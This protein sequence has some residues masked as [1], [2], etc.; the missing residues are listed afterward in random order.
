MRS[1]T[2]LALMLL[3]AA[4]LLA[5]H[6]VVPHITQQ[7][8]YAVEKGQTLAA[9]EQLAELSKKDHT[10]QLFRAVAKAVKPAVVEVHVTTNVTVGG[11]SD[12]LEEFFRDRFGDDVPFR[13]PGPPGGQPREVPRRG[14][15]SGVIIDAEEGYILTNHHVVRGADE[16]EV[17]LA[18]KRRF[19]TEWVRSDP[20]TDLAVL[21]IK[22]DRLIDAPIGDS[23]EMQVG[24]WVMAIGAPERLPQTVTAGI[25]SATSRRTG[26]VLYENFLQTDAAINKG[27]SGG[28]LVNMRGEVI[29][30]NTMIISRTGVNEG[31]GLSIP[32]NMA[33]DI[34]R[35]LIDDGRVTRGY[36]GVQIKDV[37][38]RLAEGL[39]LP[40]T[41]GSLMVQVFEG[42]PAAKAGLQV[43]DFIT[44]IDGEKIDNSDDLR[45][46]IAGV[47]PGEKVKLTIYRDGRKKQVTVEIAEQPK[48]MGLAALPGMTP[49]EGEAEIK[50]LD[51]YGLRVGALT[52]E[53]AKKYGYEKRIEGVVIT[54]VKRDSDAFQRGLRE[55]MVI[56]Q[57]QGKAVGNPG[58]LATILAEAQKGARLVVV[59]PRGIQDLV[60]ITPAEDD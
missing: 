29:G 31:L 30:I 58:E 22:P 38:R 23:D 14:L 18:D 9:R 46:L 47:R 34:M 55:G 49:E 43:G 13:V 54:G 2:L 7:I 42:T 35:Q 28:P 41:K 27:N 4:G 17:I 53:L 8:A 26:G 57:A 48:D 37:D 24:D 59:D 15:G 1:R 56:R 60:F 45:H 44:A 33:R 3:L 39:G 20:K 11:R 6:F 12:R 32:S 40:S 25:I 50:T 36:L 10:S 52:E 19:E 5:G 51:R 16:V 21:K